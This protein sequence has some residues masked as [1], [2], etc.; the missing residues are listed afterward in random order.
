MSILIYN[1]LSL[2]LASWFYLINLFISLLSAGTSPRVAGLTDSEQMESL[3]IC[4]RKRQ[5]ISR[6]WLLWG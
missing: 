1:D 3:N 6:E 4:G 5:Q 2:M